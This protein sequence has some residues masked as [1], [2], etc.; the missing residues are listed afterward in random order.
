MR[1]P[2]SFVGSARR[3]SGSRGSGRPQPQSLLLPAA[4]AG[5][6]SLPP[7]PLPGMLAPRRCLLSCL[8]PLCRS[9]APAYSSAA[10][11]GP[12]RPSPTQLKSGGERGEERVRTMPSYP[13]EAPPCP[14][15]RRLIDGIAAWGCGPTFVP[16]PN[17]ARKGPKEARGGG[18]LSECCQPSDRASGDPQGAAVTPGTCLILTRSQLAR[19]EMKKTNI[20]HQTEGEHQNQDNDTFPPR[21]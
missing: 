8:R 7:P 20:R 17:G 19:G 11:S 2:C 13:K 4:A 1:F 16:V 15:P 9:P 3:R 5:W 6:P 18:H 14:W 10:A 21:P 12:A